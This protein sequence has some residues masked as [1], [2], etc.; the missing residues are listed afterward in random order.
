MALKL[1]RG[2]ATCDK[3][4]FIHHISYKIII[5]VTYIYRFKELHFIKNKKQ[6]YIIRI[7]HWDKQNI[8]LTKR[9]YV[10]N[11]SNLNG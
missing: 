4:L 11:L 1:P 6:H 5:S 3:S 10:L 8:W 2:R 9:Q 7:E